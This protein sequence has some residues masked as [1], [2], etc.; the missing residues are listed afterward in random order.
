MSWIPEYEREIE[1]DLSVFHR[2]DN[3]DELPGSRYFSLAEFLPAYG[4]AV[5]HAIARDFAE[6]AQE[7]RAED[8]V[9][10]NPIVRDDVAHLAAKSQNNQGF[11]GIE[12]TAGG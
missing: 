9:V 10:V 12:F 5:A 3:P 6:S 1:S 11:P 8:P 2:I 4:G 7:V